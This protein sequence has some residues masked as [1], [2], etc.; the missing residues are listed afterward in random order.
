MEFCFNSTVNA[1][2]SYVELDNHRS[3]S[4]SGFVLS[5]YVS[6]TDYVGQSCQYFALPSPAVYTTEDS[7]SFFIG[8]QWV[9]GGTSFDIGRTTFVFQPTGTTA[10]SPVSISGDTVILQESSGI[11]P[12]SAP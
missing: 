12:I 4:G 6:I 7:V 9:V 5:Q 3:S 8:I 1:Y 11:S 2:L 10:V